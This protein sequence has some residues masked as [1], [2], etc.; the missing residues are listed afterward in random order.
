MGEVAPGDLVLSFQGTYT[1]RIG[2]AQSHCYESPKPTEFGPVGANWGAIGWK[3]DVRSLS[4]SRN[5]NRATP[6]SIME[7]PA[8]FPFDLQLGGGLAASGNTRLVI[9]RHVL[10]EDLVSLSQSKHG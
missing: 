5:E 2:I 6:N 9:D 1:R 7:T 4:L 10:E 8:F 3:V